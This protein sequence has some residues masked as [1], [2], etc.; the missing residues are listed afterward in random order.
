[1]I[2]WTD[3]HWRYFIRGITNKTLLFTEMTMADALVH[4]AEDLEPF[5]GHDGEEYPL[6]LQL[7]GS[8]P[9]TLG[10]AAALATAYGRY[11]SLNL[12][13]GCPSGKAKK[14]GFGA[15]LM[16]D[17]PLVRQ[18][19][20]EM[21]RRCGDSA[22]TVKCRLGVDPGRTAWDELLEYVHAVRDGG[23]RHVVV[24]AR[25]CMLHGLSPAQNRSVPPLR[26]DAVHDLVAAFPDMTFTLNGGVK[27]FEEA[28]HH[29]GHR[30]HGEDE[31]P[32]TS[33]HPV[34]GVMIGR[35]AYRNPWMFAGADAEFFR[36]G[37]QAEGMPRTR[38]EVLERY[39]VYAEDCRAKGVFGS[40]VCSIVKPLHNACCGSPAERA[41]KHALDA[42]LKR[43]A[44][45]L[46]RAWAVQCGKGP[47]HHQRAAAAELGAELGDTLGA[48]TSFTDLVWA[49]IDG[50]GVDA[51]FLDEDL[52][53]GRGVAVAAA[54]GNEEEEMEESTCRNRGIWSF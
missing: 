19:V 15:E 5:L 45:R 20:H 1:M 35:E 48:P 8:D 31:V 41:Y 53:V 23:A 42:L 54:R 26:Y 29:L 16:L 47:R 52:R 36:K 33:A 30:R 27:T 7:G 34:H 25:T 51:A 11:D 10:E 2:Q 28:R 46:D 17:P 24:H 38:R 3:R 13:S 40:N 22:V 43:H 44:Q 14:V 4:N 39:L 21:V 50:G 49:A 32:V 6:A 12:N 9:R 37:P 18:I